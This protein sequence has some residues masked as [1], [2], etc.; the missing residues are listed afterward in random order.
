MGLEFESLGQVG[1]RALEF[2][3]LVS[4]GGLRFEAS[5]SEMSQIRGVV[6]EVKRSWALAW[7]KNCW[8]HVRLLRLACTKGLVDRNYQFF[9]FFFFFFFLH[10]GEKFFEFSHQKDF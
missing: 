8:D 10:L 6:S 4:R 2:E 1:L 5:V 9:F 7:A 3:S